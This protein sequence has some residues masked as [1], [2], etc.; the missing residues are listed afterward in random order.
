MAGI[1]QII[2]MCQG[3]VLKHRYCADVHVVKLPRRK[4]KGNLALL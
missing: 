2:Q 4:G 1:G 3:K